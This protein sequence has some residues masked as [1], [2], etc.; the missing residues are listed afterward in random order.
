MEAVLSSFIFTPSNQRYRP[1][2]CEQAVKGNLV[3]SLSILKR[4][5]L[6]N[7]VHHVIWEVDVAMLPA[8]SE[9][10]R[11]IA[12]IFRRVHDRKEG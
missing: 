9:I 12:H 5:G 2:K 3:S 4:R 10:A 11:N 1:I 7:E 6:K 8:S